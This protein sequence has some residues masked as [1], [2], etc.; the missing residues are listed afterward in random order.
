MVVRHYQVHHLVR[1]FALGGESLAFHE[2]NNL[3]SIYRLSAGM[4]S[5]RLP[6]RLLDQSQRRNHAIRGAIGHDADLRAVFQ[7]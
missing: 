7:A 2:Q 6:L 4:L 1:G 3:Q 5:R